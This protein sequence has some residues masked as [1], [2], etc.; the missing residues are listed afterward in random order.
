MT[1][2]LSLDE[3]LTKLAR[4]RRAI[5]KRDRND[6]FRVRSAH[7]ADANEEFQEQPSADTAWFV[8]ALIALTL[9]DW[10]AVSCL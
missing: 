5:V 9:I 8:G 1:D 2:K 4:S 3:A 7:R 6:H 10:F